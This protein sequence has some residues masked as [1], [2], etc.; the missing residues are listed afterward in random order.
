[1]APFGLWIEDALLVGTI[2]VAGLPLPLTHMAGHPD[3]PKLSIQLQM[4]ILD[5][6]GNLVFL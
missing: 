4:Q 5:S 3:P 1:M 6:S 2:Q